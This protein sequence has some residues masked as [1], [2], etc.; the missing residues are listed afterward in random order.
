[1]SI[2]EVKNKENTFFQQIINIEG[3]ATNVSL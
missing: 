1:V 2:V 3:K